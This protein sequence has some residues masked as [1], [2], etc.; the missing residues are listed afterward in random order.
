M[1]EDARG[2][3]AASCYEEVDGP[4]QVDLL[5][6][7]IALRLR[8]RGGGY[9]D[10]MMDDTLDAITGRAIATE[11]PE[12]LVTARVWEENAPSQAMCRRAGLRHTGMAAPRVQQWSIRLLM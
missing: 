8:R 3:A 10:E 1:G 9:A 12:V 11:T 2:L 4:T 7:A 5:V 6:M